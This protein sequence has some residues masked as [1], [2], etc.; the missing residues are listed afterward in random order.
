M[1]Q[2][3]VTLTSH[4]STAW[5]DR[6][7]LKNGIM[8]LKKRLDDLALQAIKN[9]AGSGLRA[10]STVT[11]DQRQIDCLDGMAALLQQELDLEAL[12]RFA[13]TAVYLS[14]Y[15]LHRTLAYEKSID[16]FL[17]AISVPPTRS[18]SKAIIIE[19]ALLKLDRTGHSLVTVLVAGAQ[20]TIR[21]LKASSNSRKSKSANASIEAFACQLYE[22]KEAWPSRS[23]ARDK[24]WPQVQ[25]EATRRGRALSTLSG[26]TTLYRWLSKSDKRRASAS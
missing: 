4:R 9:S 25:A 13:A 2:W 22:A 11:A 6:S 26:P 19:E 23:N 21:T 5:H 24:L 18:R 20:D 17:T 1:K 16:D 8:E 7:V 10:I 15:Q 3:M 14:N 12:S